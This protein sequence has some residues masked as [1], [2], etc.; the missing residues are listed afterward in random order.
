MANVLEHKKE[1]ASVVGFPGSKPITNDRLLVT[2]CDVFV[3]AALE[4]VIDAK[5]AKKIKAKVI[6]ELANG[7]VIP[8][9]D[10][11][12]EK[13][14]II[15]VPDVLANAGGVIVSWSEWLQNK[16]GEKWSKEKVLAQLK[17]KM[18]RAFDGVWKE[19]EKR[20]KGQ[21]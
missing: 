12:L 7:P 3:P 2:N 15:S 20:S 17:E 18:G 10:K 8:E 9:A 5:N 6:L 4:N 19:S 11:I 21:V 13:R 16:K 1:T 14:K